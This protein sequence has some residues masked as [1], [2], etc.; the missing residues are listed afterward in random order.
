MTFRREREQEVFLA[1]YSSSFLGRLWWKACWCCSPTSIKGRHI[2]VGQA[3][4]PEDIDWM[5]LEVGY[6]T[7]K[8]HRAACYY[9]CGA[10]LVFGVLF[11]YEISIL[12]SQNFYL[13]LAKTATVFA[14]NLLI[15]ALLEYTTY[16]VEKHETNTGKVLSLVRKLTFFIFVNLS[17]SPLLL[18]IQAQFITTPQ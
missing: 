18:Y 13:T 14:A 3:P 4:D 12:L 6:W 10:I 17:M 11:Q 7:K 5:S 2:G 1:K 9:M 8:V 16:A 15:V